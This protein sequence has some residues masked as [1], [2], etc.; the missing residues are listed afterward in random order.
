VT[1][2][3]SSAGRAWRHLLDHRDIDEPSGT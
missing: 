1:V 3:Y 2:L